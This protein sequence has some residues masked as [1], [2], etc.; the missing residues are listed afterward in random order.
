MTSGEKTS[1]DG[2][3]IASLPDIVKYDRRT[4]SSH[5]QDGCI[6]MLRSSRIAEPPR[7]PSPSLLRQRQG[8]DAE[9]AGR[10]HRDLTPEL[11]LLTVCSFVR[12][13]ICVTPQV[14][15]DISNS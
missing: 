4:G 10:C 3:V 6:D 1:V 11:S 14:R 8:S 13:C 9:D 7:V 15:T 2:A 5:Q 12:Y